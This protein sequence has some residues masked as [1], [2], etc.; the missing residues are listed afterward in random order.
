MHEIYFCD[1]SPDC[2]GFEPESRVQMEEIVYANATEI[3]RLRTSS[4]LFRAYD[5]VMDI[6][7]HKILPRFYRS[8]EVRKCACNTRLAF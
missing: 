8:P 6:L 7:E 2:I 5:Y 1:S 3:V 4:T